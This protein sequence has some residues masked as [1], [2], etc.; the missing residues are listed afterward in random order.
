MKYALY[1]VLVEDTNEADEAIAQ[2]GA[3]DID[4]VKGNMDLAQAEDLLKSL[5]AWEEGDPQ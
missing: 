1:L 4:R 3:I 5:G 2:T